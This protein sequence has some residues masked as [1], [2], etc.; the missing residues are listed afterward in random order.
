[1]GELLEFGLVLLPLLSE[2]GKV[3]A[4]V[5]LRHLSFCEILNK[6]EMMSGGYF[7]LP[8]EIAKRA[9]I[10]TNTVETMSSNATKIC[11]EVS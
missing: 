3:V 10:A 6:M 4:L 5:L 11:D 8:A 2:L 9:T 7:N 1:M